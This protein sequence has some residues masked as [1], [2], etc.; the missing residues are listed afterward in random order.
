MSTDE[1][2]PSLQPA[3]ITLRTSQTLLLSNPADGH[4]LGLRIN[5]GI[6]RISSIPQ[7]DRPEMTLA[8]ASSIE[9]GVFQYPNTATLQLEAIAEA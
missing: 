9:Q 4:W 3:L 5:E 2:G 1:R 6:L 7:L 8:M